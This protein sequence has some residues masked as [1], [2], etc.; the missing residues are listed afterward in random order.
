MT[1]KETIKEA[2]R[3]AIKEELNPLYVEREEH[4]QHHQWI[5]QMMKWSDNIKINILRTCVKAVVTGIL[6]LVVMGFILWGRSNLV[7][8]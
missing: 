6:A 1:E 2:I 8:K 7:S 4:Y 3:E 5:S